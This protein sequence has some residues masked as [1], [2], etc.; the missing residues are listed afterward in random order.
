MAKKKVKKPNKEAGKT[1]EQPK[2]KKDF[3]PVSTEN[4][5]LKHTVFSELCKG[6]RICQEACPQKC[7]KL[8]PDKRGV[9]NNPIVECDIDKC[10]GCRICEQRCPESAIRVDR[11][12][13]DEEEDN[14]EN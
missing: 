7:I 10:T 9:Y 8:N 4:K 3:D 12:E 5:K 13:D 1:A 2:K 6:C 14:K 11:K